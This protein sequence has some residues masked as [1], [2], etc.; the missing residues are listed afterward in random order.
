MVQRTKSNHACESACQVRSE[1]YVSRVAPRKPLGKG[2][3]VLVPAVFP[4]CSIEVDSPE[5]LST[6]YGMNNN[7]SSLKMSQCLAYITV[8]NCDISFVFPWI[9]W[10]VGI[11]YVYGSF[12]LWCSV[13]P[14]ILGEFVLL[15]WNPMS[16]WQSNIIFR[17]CLILCLQYS[18]QRD[19]LDPISQL[20][21]TLINE[22]H[23]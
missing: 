11:N 13:I 10:E 21:K 2:M 18:N 5:M 19:H 17:N 8:Q 16:I 4:V 3:S 14:W 6:D 22:N 15:S 1:I 23:Q 9:K 7:C 12:Q 20:R